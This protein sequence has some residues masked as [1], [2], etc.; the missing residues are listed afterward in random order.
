[1]TDAQSKA[2]KFNLGLL[3]L[4]AVAGL[5]TLWSAIILS[6]PFFVWVQYEYA[7]LGVFHKWYYAGE[8]HGM[9]L[10]PDG[11]NAIGTKCDVQECARCGE[12][13]KVN[14]RNG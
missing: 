4:G 11:R 1:M 10:A 9:E 8:S 3:A 13:Q 12:T 14:F 6:I 5:F 7:C 2:L